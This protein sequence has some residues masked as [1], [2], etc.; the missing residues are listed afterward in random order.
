MSCWVDFMLSVDAHIKK[1]EPYP[2]GFRRQYTSLGAQ[3]LAQ[4]NEKQEKISFIQILED[5]IFI[6]IVSK[7][8]KI[9]NFT[10]SLCF[11]KKSN[12]N[13]FYATFQPVFTSSFERTTSVRFKHHHSFWCSLNI[14]RLEAVNSRNIQACLND[15][16]NV[17]MANFSRGPCSCNLDSRSPAA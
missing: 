14:F 8:S 4:I 10:I 5:K 17:N 15:S 7:Y 3:L 11:F 9:F 2:E 12:Q 13:S 1:S 6:A 16:L